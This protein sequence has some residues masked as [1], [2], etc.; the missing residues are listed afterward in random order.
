MMA[1]K[2]LRVAEKTIQRIAEREGVPVEHVRQQI[3]IAMLT[4]LC[5]TDPELKAFW[6][7]VPHE[8]DIPTPEELITYIS[9]KIITDSLIC[10]R[11]PS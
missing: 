11:W 4:G 6:D 3:R 10:R 2:N 7:S 9:R 8:A 5:S 1:N